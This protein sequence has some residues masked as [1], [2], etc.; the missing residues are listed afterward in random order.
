MKQKQKLSFTGVLIQDEDKG[1]T[2]YIAEFPEIIA[3]GDNEEEAKDNLFDAFRLMLDFK[4]ENMSINNDISSTSIIK[5]FDLEV[6]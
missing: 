3:E 2:A 6:A 4:K 5:N 1:Y